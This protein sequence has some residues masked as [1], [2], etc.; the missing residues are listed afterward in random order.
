MTATPPLEIE[1]K[2]L[3]RIPDL[4]CL[5][6]AEAHTE[7][8]IEQVYLDAPAGQTH[9]IRCRR[10]SDGGTV[11]TETVKRRVSPIACEEEERVIDA[12]EFARLRAIRP[13]NR[14][15]I[16]K[17]RHTFVY[18]NQLFEVDIYPFWSKQCVVETELSSEEEHAPFPPF[19]ELLREVSG[20]RRY[21]NAALSRDIPPEDI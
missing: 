12:E 20:D 15:I 1:R 6:T 5:R 2:Y 8:E 9:R 21:S 10:H 16:T 18:K 19:L 4:A 3:V 13:M 7:S 14:R 11:Y 17:K